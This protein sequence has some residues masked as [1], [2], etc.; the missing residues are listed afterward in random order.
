M[1]IA[2]LALGS[3]LGNRLENIKSAVELFK[4]KKI[5]IVKE[6]SVYE[7]EPLEYKK[8]L[9]NKVKKLS[10][11]KL[12]LNSVVK[13]K[14]VLSARDLLSTCQKI[15]KELGRKKTVKWGPRIIDI[16]IVFYG[17]D[18]IKE[19][20]IVIPHSQVDKRGFILFPLAE[21]SSGFVHPVLK[22]RIST[23]LERLE[24]NLKIYRV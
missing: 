6:S 14:T 20:K 8:N 3:N 17:N 18:I 7:T 13:I 12:F 21:I 5:K 4:T 2:Y 15:E 19:K 16:D 22:K 24:D 1:K 11:K 23:L 10:T 9:K